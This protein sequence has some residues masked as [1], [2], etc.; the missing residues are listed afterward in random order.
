[1]VDLKIT[2]K[3]GVT[4]AGGTGTS[5]L[6]ACLLVIGL[7]KIGVEIDTEVAVVVVGVITTAVSSLIRM[8]SNYRK[9]RNIKKGTS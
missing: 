1:M 6:L 8:V 2:G 3:K 4:E 9:H 7:K 5:F